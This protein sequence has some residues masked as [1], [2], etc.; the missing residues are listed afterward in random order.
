MFY[1]SVP[2]LQFIIWAVRSKLGDLSRL[3]WWQSLAGRSVWMA[4]KS[5]SFL[6]A[7][8]REHVSGDVGRISW[9]SL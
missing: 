3:P 7:K 6:S 5:D 1:V 8:E 2:G 4:Q 9:G